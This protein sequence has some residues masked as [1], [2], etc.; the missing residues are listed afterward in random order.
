MSRQSA[1][2]DVETG[3]ED[4]A[5]SRKLR[6]LTETEREKR[7]RDIQRVRG[8]YDMPRAIKEGVAQL[9]DKY[10]IS[11]S[12]AAATLLAHALCELSEQCIDFTKVPRNP[13]ESPQYNY[14]VED[15]YILKVLEGSESL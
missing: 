6:E 14:R 3:L 12:M 4:L 8:R 10:G 11:H 9:A 13:S 1:F 2:D 5:Q 15:A 7:L